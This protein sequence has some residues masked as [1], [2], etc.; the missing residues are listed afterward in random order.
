M[1]PSQ[2]VKCPVELLLISEGGKWVHL[3]LSIGTPGFQVHPWA[4]I[5][6][7]KSFSYFRYLPTYSQ[8]HRTTQNIISVHGSAP[9][10]WPKNLATI[11]LQKRIFKLTLC[12]TWVIKTLHYW[13]EYLH[14][15]L[16]S[17]A[18]PQ[19]IG[20][21]TDQSGFDSWISIHI[22]TG[23]AK[24]LLP[25]IALAM[26]VRLSF[27]SFGFRN[28]MSSGTQIQRVL[29]FNDSLTWRFCKSFTHKALH[30]DIQLI[31]T[32]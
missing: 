32:L 29:W 28:W 2:Y 5:N 8:V 17:P 10:M 19:G 24:G 27:F 26:L 18:T 20:I 9:N 12:P 7:P 22:K 30:S 21:S 6:N 16:V 1:A 23:W 25:Q 4:C 3:N 14:M 31:F 11:Y 15:I 13:R